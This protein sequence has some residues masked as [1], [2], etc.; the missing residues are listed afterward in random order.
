MSTQAQ[1]DGNLKSSAHDTAG[2]TAEKVSTT[3]RNNDAHQALSLLQNEY[4]DHAQSDPLYFKQWAADTNEVLQNKGVL[5][6]LSY[7]FG[8]EN[9]DKLKDSNGSLYASSIEQNALKASDDR[10]SSD[11]LKGKDLAD[12]TFANNMMHTLADKIRDGGPDVPYHWG[13]WGFGENYANKEDL[14]SHVSTRQVTLQERNSGEQEGKAL[15]PFSSLV[16]PGN[17]GQAQTLQTFISNQYGNKDGRISKDDVD[18]YLADAENP[19][20]RRAYPMAFSD[21]NR[22]FMVD[23]RDNWDAPKVTGDAALDERNQILSKALGDKAAYDYNFD[24]S[25]AVPTGKLERV[26]TPDNEAKTG[27]PDK[28]AKTGEP[29]KEAK[30]REPDKEA[31]VARPACPIAADATASETVTMK[32][33]DSLW[34]LMQKWSMS[35]DEIMKYNEEKQHLWSD[36]FGHQAERY[37]KK[38]FVLEGWN[39]M[40]PDLAWLETYRSQH[41]KHLD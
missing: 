38:D 8:A 32:K 1:F 4:R 30:T 12:E 11:R 41:Q 23:V 25:Q 35:A 2:Q 21:E 10:L 39:I 34:P 24:V 27:E 5:P 20:V 19:E 31:T 22:N 37:M 9:F 29:D 40:K 28:E 3:F 26:G 33:G 17:D 14:E 13:A 7:A 6:D 18:K 36:R 16:E 15:A